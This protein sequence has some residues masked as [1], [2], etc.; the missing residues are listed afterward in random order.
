MAV[1]INIVSHRGREAYTE[2]CGV[3]SVSL[4]DPPLQPRRENSLGSGP[5]HCP[6]CNT[7]YTRSHTVKQHFPRC[8]R[9]NGNPNSLR[10]FDHESNNLTRLRELNVPKASV[11]P[12]KRKRSGFSIASL[13]V[14]EP[15]SLM[16][17][18]KVDKWAAMAAEKQAATATSTSNNPN[19]G[20]PLATHNA[21]GVTGSEVDKSN[22]SDRP[23]NVKPDVTPT[24]PPKQGKPLGTPAASDKS[25][26]PVRKQQL[27]R[28][29]KPIVYR[30][31]THAEKSA[32]KFNNAGVLIP[33]IPGI[34]PVTER[35]F[36][37][38]QIMSLGPSRSHD[39]YYPNGEPVGGSF[40]LDNSSE[41]KGKR[42][43]RV[44]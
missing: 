29:R 20:G 3:F 2:V 35:L 9:I 27:P 18:R 17:S 23:V 43:M 30:R 7:T 37:K 21:N 31:P 15:E 36:D 14:E 26:T 5:Y 33:S 44:E 42:M 6:R 11:T 39:C 41:K 13:L 34:D 12:S 16:A 1:L 40:L 24:T 25:V 38:G 22:P 8:I 4:R 28:S 19:D 32:Y 10:W